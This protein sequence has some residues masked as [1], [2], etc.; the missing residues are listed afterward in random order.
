MLYS[1]ST[2]QSRNIGRTS[3][4]C[5]SQTVEQL[6]TFLFVFKAHHAQGHIDTIYISNEN[7]TIVALCNG[8]FSLSL[9]R[10]REG[11]TLISYRGF[12]QFHTCGGEYEVRSW[13]YHMHRLHGLVAQARGSSSRPCSLFL[14]WHTL[15]SR[16]GPVSLQPSG[17]G[18]AFTVRG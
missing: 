16:W 7:K 11:N 12:M 3:R 8:W 13:R 9:W 14:H 15:V 1:I 10:W 5:V 4:T 17:V 2:M 18:S 6:I